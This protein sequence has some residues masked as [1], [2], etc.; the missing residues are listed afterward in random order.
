MKNLF[1][2][3]FFLFLLSLISCESEQIDI[4]NNQDMKELVINDIKEKINNYNQ[5][6]QS[7]NYNSL[8]FEQSVGYPKYEITKSITKS[9]GQEIVLIP[10]TTT[11]NST[12]VKNVLMGITIGNQLINHSITDTDTDDGLLNIFMALF[13]AM[14]TTNETFDWDL[15]WAAQNLL[16]DIDKHIEVAPIDDI[17]GN[18]GGS[19]GISSGLGLPNLIFNGTGICP[20]SLNNSNSC[21]LGL[22]PNDIP[23]LGVYNILFSEADK[24]W[25]QQNPVVVNQLTNYLNDHNGIL[26]DEKLSIFL[27]HLWLAM[28]LNNFNNSFAI[29]TSDWFQEGFLQIG[30]IF[31]LTS[32]FQGNSPSNINNSSQHTSFEEIYNLLNADINNTT[33]EN[34]ISQIG[35]FTNNNIPSGQVTGDAYA[36]GVFTR[37]DIVFNYAGSPSTLHADNISVQ[38]TGNFLNSVT[39]EGHTFLEENNFNI[40]S[41][42]IYSTGLY[43]YNLLN[44]DYGHIYSYTKRYYFEFSLN[45]NGDNWLDDD[46][47]FIGFNVFIVE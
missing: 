2:S 14:P 9:N 37:L 36:G 46:D 27:D 18:G 12:T 16:N 8:S 10:T 43:S 22:G 24:T 35:G 42:G 33:F 29:G 13:A 4:P 1:Y 38:L 5:E 26:N 20:F 41:Y 28:N 3:I 47:R 31:G 39:Y 6:N 7:P 23:S 44:K 19:S 45:N 40:G 17:G 11:E 32:Q 30:N 15:F 25:L 21:T 34:N